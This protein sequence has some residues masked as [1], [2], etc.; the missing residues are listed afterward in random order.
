MILGSICFTAMVGFVKAVRGDLSPFDIIFW[1]GVLSVVLLALFARPPRFRITNRKLFVIRLVLGFAAMSCFYGAARGMAL[2]D[3]TLISKLQPILVALGAPLA[4]GAG[5]RSGSSLWLILVLGLT[6][7]GLILGPELAIGSWF[8][9]IA[10]AGAFASAGAHLALRGL[11]GTESTRAVVFW[12]QGGLAVVGF[13]A[14]VATSGAPPTLPDRSLWLPLV[15][16]GVT[17]TAG[18]LLTTRAYALDRAAV[19][20][21]AGYTSPLWAV[22]VDVLFFGLHPG[23]NALAG[24]ALVVTAGLWLV[25][26]RGEPAPPALR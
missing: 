20:A 14:V 21:A 15:A 17:A 11:G 24:G 9:L 8:G 1:R 25:R 23:W 22:L 26:G 7:T 3:L 6:G 2:T 5:E 19:I 10:L 4:L 12:F 13:L 16:I 18:Q